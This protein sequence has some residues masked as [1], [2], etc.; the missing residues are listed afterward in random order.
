MKLFSGVLTRIFSRFLDPYLAKNLP[1]ILGPYLDSYLRHFLIYEYIVFGD[2]SR[3]ELSPTAVVNNALFNVVSGR[4]VVRDYVF[5]GHNVSILTGTHDP[6]A[7]NEDRLVAIPQTGRDI[8]LNQG[9]WIASNA[10]VIGPCE[11]GEHSVVAAGSVVIRDVPP[12]TIVG[13][14]PAIAIST[15]TP[16]VTV[17]Q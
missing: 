16:P 4:I 12:Y 2:P 6:K 10:T 11:I 3:L 14:V 17:S 13:G 15:L 9:V 7:F 8:I 5:F 1:R